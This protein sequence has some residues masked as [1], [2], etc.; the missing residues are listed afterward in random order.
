MTRT[1]VGW[2]AAD[3][4]D[5]A[6]WRI[7]Y[8]APGGHLIDEVRS[9]IDAF[10]GFAI[11]DGIP[12]AD[13]TLA[14][15]EEL[16]PDLLSPLGEVLLQG[17]VDNG[18]RGWLVRDEGSKR[19]RS[20]ST[21]RS[22]VYTSKSN[23]HLDI[24]NDA[25]MEPY[26]YRV[27]LFALLAVEAAAV[28]GESILVS[29]PTVVEILAEESPDLLA[30][31][32]RPY[33]FERSHVIRPG[34]SPISWGPVFDNNAGSLRVRCN[35]QRVEMAAAVT[36]VPLSAEDIAALDALDEVLTRGELQFRHVLSRGQLLVVDDHLVVH[37]RSAF[38]DGES[39]GELR[40]RRCLVRVLLARR[41]S[42]DEKSGTGG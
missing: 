18:H 38:V 25:A 31:L 8:D 5:E 32:R 19:F 40:G 27:D 39:D 15:L 29:V 28:G 35:R 42:A 1:R 4:T 11:I 7:P 21:Y 26:G 13:R 14:E 37:G 30:R 23:D 17:P 41:P 16:A 24:H 20:D 34:Q 6:T 36:G 9:R 22:G 3:L 10:P 2:R 33:A 12:F